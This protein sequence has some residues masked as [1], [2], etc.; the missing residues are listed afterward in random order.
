MEPMW[1]TRVAIRSEAELIPQGGDE[2]FGAA[3]RDFRYFGGAV[4][5]WFPS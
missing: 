4:G 5:L 3:R 2:V 1:A